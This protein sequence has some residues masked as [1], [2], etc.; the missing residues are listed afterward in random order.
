MTPKTATTA[1]PLR[2]NGDKVD[3]HDAAV[4][5]EV[6]L[7]P[8]ALAMLA[9]TQILA[10]S[11]PAFTTGCCATPAA[12]RPPGQ[13]WLLAEGAGYLYALETKRDTMAQRPEPLG[14][15]ETPQ[16]PAAARSNRCRPS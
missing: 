6:P 16:A 15:A 8:F 13:T 1:P 9:P 12:G 4:L 7:E 5:L 10:V 2:L 3:A 11:L 14:H